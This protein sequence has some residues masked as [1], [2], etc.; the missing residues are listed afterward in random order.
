MIETLQLLQ[1]DLGTKLYFYSGM[2]HHNDSEISFEQEINLISSLN[3][4]ELYSSLYSQYVKASLIRNG[5]NNNLFST[6][7]SILNSDIE[8]IN[9]VKKLWHTQG[10][11]SQSA[12]EL[13]VH[14]NTLIYRIDRMKEMYF[15][16][17]KDPS[18][19]LIAY[20]LV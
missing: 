15:L 4:K 14:R 9:L 2:T 16:D 20:L 5:I 19:L 12:S 8:T 1:D 17:L 7:S 11:I 3:H 13:Y 6:V 10:N 18:V